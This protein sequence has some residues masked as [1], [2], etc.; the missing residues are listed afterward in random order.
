MGLALTAVFAVAGCTS[1]SAPAP[2]V[3]STPPAGSTTTSASTTS[4]ATPTATSATSTTTSEP[5]TAATDP[6]VPAAARAQTADGAVA[7]TA[8]FAAQAN[9]S[10]QNLKPELL[11]LLVLQECKTCA[12]M[13]QQVNDYIARKQRYEAEFISPTA[14]TIS[15]ASDDQAQVFLSTD[16]KGGRVVDSNGNTVEKLPPQQGNVTFYLVYRSGGWRVSEIK[17]NA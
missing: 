9:A 16:S 15:S 13:I 2:G 3:S 11:N 17:T 10:Y 7:F 4:S 6:N 5:S 12:A 8:Y 1:N 14:I